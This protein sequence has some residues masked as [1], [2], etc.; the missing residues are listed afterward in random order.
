M[1]A[2]ATAAVTVVADRVEPR[3]NHGFADGLNPSSE[4]GGRLSPL[5]KVVGHAL[6][7]VVGNRYFGMCARVRSDSRVASA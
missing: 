4:R 1:V 2:A 6:A 7:A 5:I 3:I